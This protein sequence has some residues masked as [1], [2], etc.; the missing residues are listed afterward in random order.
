M[1]VLIECSNCLYNRSE[2]KGLARVQPIADFVM[3]AGKPVMA[4]PAI[5]LL[6]HI[7]VRPLCLGPVVFIPTTTCQV[8][9]KVLTGQCLDKGT[10][11]FCCLCRLVGSQGTT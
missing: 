5:H 11:T 6:N 9:G 8:S 3:V 10:L 7:Q 4:S 1:F 2:L